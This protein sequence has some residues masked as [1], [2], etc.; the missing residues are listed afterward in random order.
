VAEAARN[1]TCVGARPL[2][3][4]DCLNFGNPEKDAVYF[5]F[6]EAVRGIAEACRALHAPVVSGNV[7][8]Y[9]ESPAGAIHPTPTIGMVGLLED[10]DERPRGEPVPGDL[11]VLV[12]AN[13]GHLAP[14]P[15][16]GGAGAGRR[17]G[18]GRRS[19][20]REAAC[21]IVPLIRPGRPRP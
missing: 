7:S 6:V 9:N 18:S 17:A 15:A 10:R 5:Q 16:V 21:G 8:F 14:G 19:G 12:G 20:R 1:V 11:I 2:A 13:G 4:T 3:V